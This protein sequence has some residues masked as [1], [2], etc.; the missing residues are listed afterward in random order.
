M[1]EEGALPANAV[2]VSVMHMVD[3][4]TFWVTEPLGQDMKKEREELNYLE[5]MLLAHF[6]RS[7]HNF[8][9]INYSPEEGEVRFTLMHKLG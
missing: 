3:P 4:S 5:G 1:A 9:A 7:S 6:H 8:Q 2:P